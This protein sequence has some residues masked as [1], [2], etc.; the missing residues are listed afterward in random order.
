MILWGES[1]TVIPFAALESLR[2][3]LGDPQLITVPGTHSWLLADPDAFGE[4]ITNVIGVAPRAVRQ[5]T[6]PAALAQA[7]V[8]AQWEN[9]RA[10]SRVAPSH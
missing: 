7:L 6:A 8:G 5:A 4:V 9:R 2:A 1:D 3:A 10:W